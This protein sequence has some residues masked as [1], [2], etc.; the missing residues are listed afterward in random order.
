MAPVIY[1]WKSDSS[2]TS[3]TTQHVQVLASMENLAPSS[4]PFILGHTVYRVLGGQDLFHSK[5]Q[6]LN[7]PSPDRVSLR[8][9]EA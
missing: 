9:S 6:I 7:L 2:P 8:A 3:K 1:K 4:V 5:Y